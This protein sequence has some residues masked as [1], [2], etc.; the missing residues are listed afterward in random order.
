M[1]KVNC[2]CLFY[3]VENYILPNHLRCEFRE[4][5]LTM[6]NIN[7]SFNFVADWHQVRKTKSVSFYNCKTVD[8]IP[9]KILNEFP[10]LVGLEIKGSEMVM[11]NDEMFSID[12][13]MLQNLYLG[14][15][16]IKHI[17]PN[18]F[19]TLTEL[20]WISFWDNQIEEIPHEIF[21]RNQKLEFIDFSNNRVNL[22]HPQL[23]DGLKNLKEVS[24]WNNGSFSK[25]FENEMIS[26]MYGELKPLFDGFLKKYGTVES[27]CFI[28]DQR[29]KFEEIKSRFLEKDKMIAN[30]H[31]KLNQLN[32][33]VKLLNEEMEKIETVQ[34]IETAEN[35]LDLLN[36][37]ALMKDT[38]GDFTIKF[39]DGSTLTAHKT[40]L[41]GLF[42]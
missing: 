1:E 24:F 23:F 33:K 29:Q 10:S 35:L 9:A 13:K 30:L 36:N 14:S 27:E 3:E 11:I 18:A 16:Q 34:R 17:S 5:D 40:I 39:E 19:S 6:K 42:E 20:K 38:N 22:L 15:C 8:F 41:K 21:K 25:Y 4:V 37:Y 7:S 28:S 2:K 32:Q 12:F 31:L 26:R